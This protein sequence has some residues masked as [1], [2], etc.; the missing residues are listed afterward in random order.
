MGMFST[1]IEMIGRKFGRL[2]VI[3]ES[4]RRG[5]AILWEC[6]CN[7]GNTSVVFGGAL[8]RGHTQS[9]GCLNKEKITKHGMWGTSTYDSWHNMLQRCN[10]PKATKFFNYGGRGIKVCDHWLK[11]ENFLEDMG[12]KPNGFTIERIDNDK[13]YSPDNCKWS[14]RA[15][16]ERNKRISSRNTTGITGVGWCSKSQKYRVR[17]TLSGR[18]EIN[19]GYFDNIEQATI[20]R[21]Q[22]EQ[23]YWG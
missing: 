15:E 12:L 6:L 17:I 4:G 3:R 10:N 5:K 22:A 21:K 16:Q 2:T 18:K 23:K 1:K 9:C 11:F 8:R 20:V 19:L 13:D 14:S 7:C